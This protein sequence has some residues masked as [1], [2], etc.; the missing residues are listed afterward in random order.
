M[1]Q[2]TEEEI[3]RIIDNCERIAQVAGESIEE[4]E[5]LPKIVEI[6]HIKNSPSVIQTRAINEEQTDTDE[7]F[8]SFFQKTKEKKTNKHVKYIN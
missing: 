4:A 8:E 1:S 3:D 6:K 5:R 7:Y 2:F